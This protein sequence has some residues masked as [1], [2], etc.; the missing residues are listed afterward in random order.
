MPEVHTETEWLHDT[1]PSW[2][3]W[4]VSLVASPGRWDCIH[5]PVHGLARTE[6]T[7]HFRTLGGIG[8]TE[9]HPHQR[10]PRQRS[11][12]AQPQEAQ[13]SWAV[14]RSC[15]QGVWSIRK[16]NGLFHRPDTHA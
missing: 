16:C 12:H 11:W 6:K 15:T 13:V 4:S 14:V 8:T 10:S 1:V 3:R 9:P 5:A 2:V 7:R